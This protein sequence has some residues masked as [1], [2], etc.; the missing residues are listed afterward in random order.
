MKKSQFHVNVHH[1][2]YSM[3]SDPFDSMAAGHDPDFMQP[4][5][6]RL[7]PMS[8]LKRLP[9]VF[10]SELNLFPMRGVDIRGS[11]KQLA[12]SP[13]QFVLT[14]RTT[15]CKSD[16]KQ[17]LWVTLHCNI[18][19]GGHTNSR[20]ANPQTPNRPHFHEHGMSLKHVLVSTAQ[21]GH[22]GLYLMLVPKGHD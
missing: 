11:T 18:Y 7:N 1:H 9:W 6:L 16:C 14:S 3:K 10:I 17:N 15:V 8:S 4:Y 2:L 22:S 5:F 19:T 12:A 13:K 21:R 20:W